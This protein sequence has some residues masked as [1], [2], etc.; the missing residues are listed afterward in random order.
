[1]PKCISLF[2]GIN[3]GG[4]HMVRMQDLKG[5][6]E[7]LGLTEVVTYIQSGN[8]V[9]H[10]DDTDMAQ[11]AR[12]LEESFAQK[13]GFQAN[14]VLR[15]AIDFELLVAQNPFQH[16]QEKESKWIIVLFLAT[17]PDPGALDYLKQIYSGP[18]TF[19]LIGQELFIYYP[20]GSGRSKL[21]NALLDRALKTSG[22]ARNWNT[23]L[24]LQK[25]LQNRS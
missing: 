8:V 10:S 16:D 15:T 2:R 14:V 22:T 17:H 9:F 4:H 19:H 12:R 3:V 25:L 24:Q 5:L 7:T 23:V 6:H 18:E 21:T 20:N 11:L 1:M 13:F